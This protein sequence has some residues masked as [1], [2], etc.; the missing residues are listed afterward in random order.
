MHATTMLPMP[1]A[2]SLRA[3]QQ[4]FAQAVMAHPPGPQP[5]PGAAAR[6]RPAPDG[7]PA[8]FGVYHRAYRARMLAALRDNHEALAQALGDLGFEALGLAWLAAHP[9]SQPSIRWFG[10]GLADFMQTLSDD[11]N[12]LVPHPALVDLARL[13]TA[14]RDAF[15]AAD[16]PV[17]TAAD[18]AALPPLAWPT[19][20]LHLHPSVRQLALLWQVGPTW[21]ALRHHE[22][23]GEPS[24]PAPEHGPHTLLAWRH[25]LDTHWRSLP[26]LEAQLLAAVADGQTFAE[27][28]ELAAQALPD[29]PGQAPQAVVGALQQWLADG[30][31]SQVSHQAQ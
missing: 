31:I 24:L 18:L 23:P 22:G 16:A 5:R 7:T 14:L 1:D 10:H 28:C 6:L 17:I 3:L 29:Q 19:L 9:S 11:D 21:H 8:R 30:L 27:L 12:P 13:D 2:A 20:R 25:H 26:P 15:D 4:A